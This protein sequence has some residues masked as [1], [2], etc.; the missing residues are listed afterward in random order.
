LCIQYEQTR[1][2]YHILLCNIF[3]TETNLH[4]QYNH[5]RCHRVTIH[6]TFLRSLTMKKDNKLQDLRKFVLAI[7]LSLIS[8]HTQYRGLTKNCP[9]RIIK[10]PFVQNIKSSYLLLA[11]FLRRLRVYRKHQHQRLG[12]NLTRNFRRK[13]KG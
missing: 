1:R 10:C 9:S 4:A 11:S 3:N 7:R 2:N 6:I 12:N 5:V 13:T 8:F